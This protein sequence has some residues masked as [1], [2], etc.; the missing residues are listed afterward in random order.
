MNSSARRP[1]LAESK[2]L[3]REPIAVEYESGRADQLLI[4][5]PNQTT[6]N[7]AEHI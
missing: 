3:G 5:G 4:S 7:R 1:T 2:S 6:T